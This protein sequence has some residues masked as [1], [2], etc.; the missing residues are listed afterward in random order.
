MFKMIAV[1]LICVAVASTKPQFPVAYTAAA[2]APLAYSA[3]LVAGPGVVTATSSQVVAR[4]Y[5]GIAAPIV[6]A[7]PYVAAPAAALPYTAAYSS[8]PA[9][10]AAYTAGYP[11]AAAYRYP[12]S[13]YVF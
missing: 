11:Y 2:A 13:P 4:N 10:S 6:A 7:A 9:Y 8:Y 5:N 1:L 12:Y 3:P